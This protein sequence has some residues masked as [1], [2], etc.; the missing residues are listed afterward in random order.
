MAVYLEHREHHAVDLCYADDG[1][2]EMH[3]VEIDAFWVAMAI[4][5]EG[6]FYPIPRLGVWSDNQMKTRGYDMRFFVMG[7]TEDVDAY[8]VNVWSEENG[9]GIQYAGTNVIFYR[10]GRIDADCYGSQ[11]EW[12]EHREE[13]V[14]VARSGQ[15]GEELGKFLRG[16]PCGD[17]V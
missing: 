8:V 17:L 11:H 16:E 7:S 3:W 1:F 14:A 12:A 13:I 5:H 2:G 9:S 6:G 15:C 4:T 10:D